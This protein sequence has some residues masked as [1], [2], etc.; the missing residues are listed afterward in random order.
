[1]AKEALIQD[2]DVWSP[3]GLAAARVLEAC[4]EQKKDSERDTSRQRTEKE[5]TEDER[6]YI[7]Q[8]L[9][10]IERFEQLYRTAI[11]GSRR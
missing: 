7:D 5:K 4:E 8:R 9:R 11:K 10:D 2:N 6:R 3:I 1:M